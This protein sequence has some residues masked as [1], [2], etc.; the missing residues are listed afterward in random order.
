MASELAALE[1]ERVAKELGP[2]TL[3]IDPIAIAAKRDIEVV[4][5]PTGEGAS[6][7]LLRLGDQ[8]VIGYATHISS[9]G[10]QRFS[11]AH[12]LGHYF[13]SG[14]PEK[15]FDANGVHV[16]RA[17]FASKDK[18]EHEADLFAA[19]LLMP[20]RLFC[21][22]LESA[23]E[24]LDAI[25]SLAT[26]CKTSLTATAIRF[27]ECTTDAVAIVVSKGK[28]IEYC[29]MS[30]AFAELEGIRWLRKK[31]EV[32]P[33]TVTY[34]LNQKSESERRKRREGAVPLRRW[35]DGGPHVE[36]QEQA[37]G[38]GGYGRSLTVLYAPDLDDQVEANDD[39]EKLEASWTP[40]FSKSRRR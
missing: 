25:E 20:R 4:K 27:T 1:G 33:D 26:S 12:E 8:F 13:L 28:A 40:T 22:S 24:G 37:I 9:E 21:A 7:M 15:V 14:H 32:P 3:P 30:D 23:G 11:I 39:E 36:V 35:F 29:R 5:K 16:S 17:G 34:Y 19:S 31:D 18:Y 6:G 38:L 2:A 10:F